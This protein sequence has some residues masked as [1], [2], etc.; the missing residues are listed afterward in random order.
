MSST[1]QEWANYG[2]L[3]FQWTQLP[4]FIQELSMATP[5]LQGQSWIVVTETIGLTKPKIF[6]IW[7]YTEKACVLGDGCTH[8]VG[9]T[10]FPFMKVMF[11]SLSPPGQGGT[12]SYF[13]QR[14]LCVYSLAIVMNISESHPGTSGQS[15]NQLKLSARLPARILISPRNTIFIS[16][17]KS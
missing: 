9:G 3:G 17:I 16:G 11:M 2:L 14:S 13:A 15:S 5:A 12:I 7:P 1:Y 4:S 8:L 6:T 10:S